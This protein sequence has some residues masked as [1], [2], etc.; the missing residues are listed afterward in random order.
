MTTSN[1]VLG[2]GGSAVTV[3]TENVR[4]IYSKTLT[5]ITP[6][7]STSNWASGPKPTKIVDLLIIEIRFLV[8]GHINSTDQ[9]ALEGLLTAGGVFNMTWKGD[10]Y[11]INMEKFEIVDAD[12][13][14][15]NDELSVTFTTL[16]GVNI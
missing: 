11:N 6:P 8:I 4:K 1:M 12:S 16:V 9:T 5:K 15:E 10:N 13:K 14:K 7:Q 2:T 3:Y